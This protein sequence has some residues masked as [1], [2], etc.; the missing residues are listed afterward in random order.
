MGLGGYVTSK[1]NLQLHGVKERVI[2]L[3]NLDFFGWLHEETNYTGVY[4]HDSN[5]PMKLLA[6]FS[7]GQSYHHTNCCNFK[8]AC[9]SVFYPLPR[10]KP[11]QELSVHCHSKIEK[12]YKIV[13]FVC[14]LVAYVS[15]EYIEEEDVLVLKTDNF[16]TALEEFPH[17]LVEF[18]KLSS[19]FNV[20]MLINKVYGYINCACFQSL[21]PLSL[22]LS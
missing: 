14:L 19:A 12:M 21:L 3:D 17:I 22:M 6:D 9:V 4:A 15:S 11:F 2:V 1:I 10:W 13:A 7:S 18:C 8:C 5:C 20:L 16:E